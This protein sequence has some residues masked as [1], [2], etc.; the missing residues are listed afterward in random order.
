[1]SS[2][3][4]AEKVYLEIILNMKNGYVLRFTD[5]EFG[6]LFNKHGINIHGEKYEIY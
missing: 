2:L 3:T 4:S 6:Q 1:M 5:V